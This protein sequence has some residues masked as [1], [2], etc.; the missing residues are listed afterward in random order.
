MK[1][2]SILKFQLIGVGLCNKQTL[3]IL[4]DIQKICSLCQI[5]AANL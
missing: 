4:T 2:K 3:Q 1:L 5:E